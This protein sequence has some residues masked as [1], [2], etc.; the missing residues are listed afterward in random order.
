[1]KYRISRS[2]AAAMFPAASSMHMFWG[3]AIDFPS[4]LNAAWLCPLLGFLIASPLLFAVDQAGKT[5]AESP[6]SI[7]LGNLPACVQRVLQGLAALLMAYDLSAVMRLTA[8]SSNIIALGDVTVHLL[9]VPLGI[10]VAVLVL[11]GPD[12][13]GNSTRIVMYVLPVFIAVMLA[14]QLK[15]YRPA[16]LFPLLGNGVQSIAAGGIYCAG[17]I[18]IMALIWMVSVP[19]RNDRSMLRYAFLSSFCVSLLLIGFHMSFPVMPDGDFT[20]AARIE[21]FLSNGRLSLSPQFILNILWYS[22]LLLLIAAEAVTAACY[23][24]NALPGIPL[25]IVSVVI[26]VGTSLLAIFNPEWLKN[27]W[28]IPLAAFPLIGSIFA[29]L[30]ILKLFS[31]GGRSICARRD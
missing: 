26:A 6:F 30:M 4:A 21:L 5:G 13:S 1:M 2:A 25:W 3:M 15:S 19:E 31:K 17:V 8:S 14:V 12:A 10:V 22:G 11:L 23:F 18:S 27:A 24:H 20:E 9:I 16:W 28:K 29:L 7:V